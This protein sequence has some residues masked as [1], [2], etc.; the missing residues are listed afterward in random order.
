MGLAPGRYA[1]GPDTGS[2]HLRTSRDGV[3]AKVGHDLLIEMARWS[4]TV[5]I[6]GP[7]PSSASVEA[8]IEMASFTVLE[9]TG[10]V[11]PLSTHDRKDITGTSLRLMDVAGHPRATFA[12]SAI[13]RSNS[14]ATITGTLTV[15][16]HSG[17]VSLR[18]TETGPSAWRATGTILQSAYGI[19]PYRAFLG[20]LRVADRIDIEVVV[21]LSGRA[22]TSTR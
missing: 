18:V 15:R 9:G 20:A 14:G 5:T 4:G 6:A 2:L 8:G 10:G 17:E 1:I 21:D 19:K 12:S 22:A 13:T 7:D 3:A 11:M 16:K